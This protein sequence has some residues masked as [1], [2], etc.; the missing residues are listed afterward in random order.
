MIFLHSIRVA[1]QRELSAL[2]PTA[3]IKMSALLPES[4]HVRCN[5][6]MSALCQKR[7][8][9]TTVTRLDP[10]KYEA[11]SH[12]RVDDLIAECL[13]G[14]IVEAITRAMRCDQIIRINL[15]EFLNCFGNVVV[16]ERR[17][18]MEATDYRPGCTL[19]TPEASIAW[20]TVLITPRWLH[21]VSTTSP[22]SLTK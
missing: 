21:E 11:R 8:S 10:P 4:G 12:R 13:P 9:G 19:L 16:I 7:T 14:E 18:D 17:N 15:P 5:Y 20:R 22:L 3:N 2:P 6:R 1:Q